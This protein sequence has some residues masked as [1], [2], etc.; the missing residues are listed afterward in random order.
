MR[1]KPM[2]LL[3]CSGFIGQGIF[4]SEMLLKSRRRPPTLCPAQAREEDQRDALN[5]F[6]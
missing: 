2:A 1:R 5:S 4:S 3:P 6:F